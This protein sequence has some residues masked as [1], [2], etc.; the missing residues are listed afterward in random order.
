MY[1]HFEHNIKKVLKYNEELREI[2]IYI[3]IMT[4]TGHIWH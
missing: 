3:Y 4:V 2:R 1:T